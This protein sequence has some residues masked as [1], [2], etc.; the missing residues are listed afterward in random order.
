MAEGSRKINNLGIFIILRSDRTNKETSILQLRSLTIR[1]CPTISS[2]TP[3]STTSINLWSIIWTRNQG[4][5]SR[6]RTTQCTTT[7][8]SAWWTITTRSAT[9]CSCCIT[10][11]LISSWRWRSGC[12]TIETRPRRWE[13]N[14]RNQDN[15]RLLTRYWWAPIKREQL[16]LKPILTH[17]QRTVTR[18]LE[19]TILSSN[20]Q[21]PGSSWRLKLLV[22][23]SRKGRN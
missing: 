8:T 12:A 22:K 18:G 5:A 10:H 16:P 4:R 2:A 7:C 23:L 17:L 14:S 11:G 1:C 19:V 13:N 15:L 21:I 3:C 20:G 9:C 6:I